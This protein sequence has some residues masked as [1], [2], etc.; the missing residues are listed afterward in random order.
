MITGNYT[1]VVLIL[2]F[3]LISLYVF[4]KKDRPKV[5]PEKKGVYMFFGIF[6]IVSSD[7]F[8]KTFGFL[9]DSPLMEQASEAGKSLNS[10]PLKDKLITVGIII[11][12]FVSITLFVTSIVAAINGKTKE[13]K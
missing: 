11:M 1:S 8:I 12:F 6:P 3:V 7:L 10:T 13:S 9:D 2:C 4:L 5:I